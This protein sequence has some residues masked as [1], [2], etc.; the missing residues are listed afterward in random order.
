MRRE[1]LTG[2]QYSLYRAFLG[3]FMTVHFAHLLPWASEVFGRGGVVSEPSF[4]PLMAALPQFLHVLDSPL[5]VG[6]LLSVGAIAGLLIAVGYGDRAAALGCALLLAYLHARNPLI[7]NPSLPMLGWLLVAHAFTPPRPHG[8]LAAA[9]RG[10]NAAWRLPVEIYASAF[11]VLALSYSYSGYTKLYSP[12]WVSGDA[13]AEVLR[14]PL[15]RDHA[16]RDLLLGLPP[17]FLKALTWFVIAVELLFAPLA[18]FRCLRFGLWLAMLAIQFGFLLFLDFA[19][20]TAPMLLVHLLTF[21]PRWIKPDAPA[22]LLYDG[23][24]G[25]CH[26]NVRFALIEDAQSRLQFAS[27]QSRGGTDLSSIVLIDDRGIEYRRSDAAIGVLR[28][29]GGYWWL[30]GSL[31]SLV[32]TTLRD[33]VY[34]VIGRLRYTLGQRFAADTCPVLPAELLH[35]LAEK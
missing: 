13:I 10:V 8:S 23:Q 7:A 15:A 33:R 21:D 34:D 22:T 31:I 30:V 24:C 12:G 2:G 6:L 20:L 28:R 26:A 11:V 5:A 25:F 35:R 32:P 3:A 19:D 27:L 18:V 14:N 9:R 16:L 4:S 29:L 17:I 1:P